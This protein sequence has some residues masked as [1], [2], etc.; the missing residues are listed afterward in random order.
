M[1]AH[2]YCE[3]C[4]RGIDYHEWLRAGFC[5]HC[6]SRF[7]KSTESLGGPK[8]GGGTSGSVQWFRELQSLL[9]FHPA[10]CSAVGI[11]AGTALL[12]LAPHLMTI[13]ITLMAVGAAVAALSCYVMHEYCYP[14][15]GVGLKLGMA[16]M[17]AGAIFYASSYVLMAVGGLSLVAGIGVGAYTG[18]RASMKFIEEKRIVEGRCV[19]VPVLA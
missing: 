12:L 17:A 8:A 15:L 6:G 14:E 13:G 2:R 9:T 16:L 10:V 11:G 4:G 5:N 19:S 3:S 7:Y 1:D 18:I